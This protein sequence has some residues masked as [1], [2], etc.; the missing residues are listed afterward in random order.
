MPSSHGIPMKESRIHR[1]VPEKGFLFDIQ[2]W[3]LNDGKGIRT[4]VFFKGCPLKCS[5]C[6]NPESQAFEPEIALFPEK[7]T[8]C[9]ACQ[10]ACPAGVALPALEGGFIDRTLCLG[11]GNCADCCVTG[12]RELMGK[13]YCVGEVL[14]AVKKDMVFYRRSGGGVTFSGGEPTA[15]PSF[16]LKL[17]TRC[18]ELGMDLAIETCGYFDWGKVQ[19]IIR[20]MDQVFIDLKH[21]DPRAHKKHTGFDNKLIMENTKRISALEIP[22]VARIPVVPGINDTKENIEKTAKFVRNNLS[23]CIGIELLPY[24]SLGKDKYSFLGRPYGLEHIQAPSEEKIRSLK[25]IISEAQ[26]S[27]V[28]F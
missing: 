6:C 10:K 13:E 5:W 1:A 14:E 26:V 9:G 21:M 18:K 22:M 11:C 27:L 28:N 20:M 4:L 8:N 12:A 24:H 3:S 7:C 17:A 25:R 23:S 15:Q 16:L 2:R 19:K